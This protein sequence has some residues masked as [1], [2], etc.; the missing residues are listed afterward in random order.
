MLTSIFQQ[1]LSPEECAAKYG[2]TLPPDFST[3]AP[4]ASAAPT[5][6]PSSYPAGNVSVPSVPTPSVDGSNYTVSTPTS[7]VL[8]TGA[9]N[10]N[11]NADVRGLTAVVLGALGMLG[12]IL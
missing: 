1:G 3:L 11:N 5:A 12:L 4:A 7:P 2:V 10:F 8:Y 9:A 6:A